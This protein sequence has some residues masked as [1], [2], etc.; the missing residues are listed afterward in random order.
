[1]KLCSCSRPTRDPDIRDRRRCS[2]CTG[3][4]PPARTISAAALDDLISRAAKFLPAVSS[5][6][7]WAAAYPG[8]TSRRRLGLRT[9]P[10]RDADEDDCSTTGCPTRTD[11]TGEGAT[12]QR[13]ALVGSWRRLAASFVIEALHA[14]ELADAALGEAR[15][16]CDPGPRDHVRSAYFEEFPQL[17]ARRDIREAHEAKARRQARGEDFGAA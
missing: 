2:A 16:V 12:D 9:P 17:E 6:Y 11:P 13:G 10:R 3:W 15:Y 8:S 5:E 4:C 14:L 1:V 7:R